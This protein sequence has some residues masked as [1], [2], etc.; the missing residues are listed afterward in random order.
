[1]EKVEILTGVAP[2]FLTA[3]TGRLLAV[4]IVKIKRRKSKV[5]V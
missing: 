5:G 2:A 4:N 1:M 3:C